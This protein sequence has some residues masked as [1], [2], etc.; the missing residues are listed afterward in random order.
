MKSLP[1]PSV[2]GNTE[3]ERFDNAVRAIRTVSK[4]DL[5]K[6]ETEWRRARARKKREKG[7]R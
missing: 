1:A 3:F 7:P 5:L 2:S 6:A 4:E